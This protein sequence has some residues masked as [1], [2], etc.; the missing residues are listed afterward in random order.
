[1]GKACKRRYKGLLFIV[2]TLFLSSNSLRGKLPLLGTPKKLKLAL[3]DTGRNEKYVYQPAIDII[4]ANNF[5]VTY[6]PL[7]SIGDMSIEKLPYS[8]YFFFLLCPEFLNTVD[9]SPLSKKILFI[10][11]KY[12][13]ISDKTI[14]LIF[15]SRRVSRNNPI[16]PFIDLL[17]ITSKNFYFTELTNK[18]LKL[19]LECRLQRYHTT[20]KLPNEGI[21]FNSESLSTSCSLLPFDTQYF[22]Q[23][24]KNLLPF[25]IHWYN[26]TR[27]NNIFISYKSIFSFSGIMENF[28]MCPMDYKIKNNINRA[29]SNMIEQLYYLSAYNVKKISPHTVIPPSAISNNST[30]GPNIKKHKIAWMDLKTGKQQKELVDFILRSSIDYLWITLNP[31]MYYSP[32]AKYKNKEKQFIKNLSLFTKRLSSQAKI[33]N[34]I[35]PKIF[36]GFEITNN[37]YKPNLPKNCAYDL[38]GNKYDDIPSPLD[39][40]FWLYEVKTPLVTFLNV[41]RKKEVSNN[42]KL[43]GVILDLE[44]YLRKSTG[45]FL[46]TMGFSKKIAQRFS[47]ISP[48]YLTSHL[49]EKKLFKKYFSHLESEAKALGKDLKN[50]FNKHL[51]GST[52]GCYA[53]NISVD[54][55]YKNFYKGLSRKNR[56]IYLLTFNSEFS[57]HQSWLK[58]NNINTYHSGVLMLSKIKDEKDFSLFK[59]VLN[60]NH[61]IWINR[62][63]RLVEPIVDNWSKLEQTPIPPP[64]RIPLVDS[65]QKVS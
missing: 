38:Y 48:I 13:L 60:S 21:S 59:K 7:S 47:K 17:G 9:T 32:I 26:H 2:A 49:I 31:H 27:K 10:I 42:I 46:P 15:P 5:D 39:R 25:G 61:S 3:F 43:A 30:L 4:E 54:W 63:S 40:N 20:L 35:P 8:D 41:W 19:P 12:S 37:L 45:A 36:I 1:M 52:V 65:L 53:P 24:I 23:N 29:F 51:P 28:Q 34:I 6:Y 62:F 44:M 11:K 16:D 14:G 57:K 55:F 50:F 56:P 33:K 58:K 18:F 64:K 22:S